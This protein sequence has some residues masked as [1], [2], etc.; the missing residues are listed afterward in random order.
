MIYIVLLCCLFKSYRFIQI[1]QLEHYDFKK[2]L[3]YVFNNYIYYNMI[4]LLCLF[5]IS[6]VENDICDL[7]SIIILFVFISLS[8]TVSIVKLK[9]TSKIKRIYLFLIPILLLVFL[10]KFLILFYLVFEL[11]ILIPVL[12]NKPIDYLI[13]KKYLNLSTKKFNNFNNYKIGITG[14]YGKTS[15]K[16]IINDLLQNVLVG[17]CSYKSYNTLLGISKYINDILLEGHEYVLLEY[18]AS[19]KGDIKELTKYFNPNIVCV[20]EIGYMHL[21]TFKTIE[22]IVLE[23]MSIL[24]NCD[25]AI[26]NYEQILIREYKTDK[27][28][29]SY[30]FNYG[31]YQAKNIDI[32]IGNTKFDLFYKE[33]FISTINT[34]LVGKHQI[35]NLLCAICV[36]HYLD[37]DLNSMLENIGNLENTENRLVFKKFKKYQ[38]IDD[39]YNANVVGSINALEILSKVDTNKIIITPGY[40]ENDKVEE[41]LYMQFAKKIIEVDPFVILVG[42]K[43]TKLLQE[44]LDNNVSYI[45][46]KSFKQA[47]NYVNSLEEYSTILIENDLPDNYKRVI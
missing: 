2:Y 20:T 6:F 35:L 7:I 22:N 28:V 16:N 26:L 37:I 5:C 18:G 1:L 11:L 45:V 23:K 9:F 25:V 13:N 19:K 29:I 24:D 38:I 36:L 46:V 15:T 17:S 43:Q 47:M 33:N 41:E 10:N 32:Q 12:L 4:P 14:S 42:N 8:T 21:N 40:V 27:K 30:G 34:K 3:Y 44:L 39:S 31:D